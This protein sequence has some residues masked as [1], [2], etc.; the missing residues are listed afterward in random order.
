MTLYVVDSERN[1]LCQAMEKQKDWC[2]AELMDSEDRLFIMYTSG[3]SDPSPTGIVHSQAGY[4]LYVAMTH[5]V[6]PDWALLI[7]E[8]H[9]S[10]CCV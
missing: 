5:Q 6:L 8:R 7:G 3:T 9:I 2:S 4:L 1:S 10:Q